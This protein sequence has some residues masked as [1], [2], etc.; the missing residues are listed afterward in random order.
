VRVPDEALTQLVSQIVGQIPLG[1]MADP[2]EIAASVLF[3]AA[4]DSSFVV[5]HDLVVDGGMSSL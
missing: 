1:R 2:E 4:S 5:G 3:L